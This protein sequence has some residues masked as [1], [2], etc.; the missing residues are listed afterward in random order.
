[1]GGRVCSTANYVTACQIGTTPACVWGYGPYGSACTTAAIAGTKFCNLGVSYDSNAV[2]AGDQD[3]LQPTDSS[4]LLNCYADWSG[5]LGNTG[6][7]TTMHDITGNVREITKSAANVY[8]LMG[9]SFL[10]DSEV[11]AACGLGAFVADGAARLEDTGF[12]CCFD[13]DPTQ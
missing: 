9:G 1:M 4:V 3:Q 8:P 10:N 2:A 7:A 6:V 5:L 13:Q 11:G 12:R